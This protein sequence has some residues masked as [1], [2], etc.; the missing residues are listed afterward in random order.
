[1]DVDM[2]DI[3]VSD[4]QQYLAWLQA[5]MDAA[6][7]IITVVDQQWKLDLWTWSIGVQC[8]TMFLQELEDAIQLILDSDLHP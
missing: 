5:T 7:P 8:W 3:L 6:V 4:G 2:N 1:M